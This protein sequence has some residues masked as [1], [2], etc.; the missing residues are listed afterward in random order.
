MPVA[1]APSSAFEQH[2]LAAKLHNVEKQLSGVGVVDRRTGRDFDHG[3]LAVASVTVAPRTG[4]PPL[5]PDRARSRQV[6]ERA[7]IAAGAH[8]DVATATA[9]AAVRTTL[10]NVFLA[11]ERDRSRPAGSRCDV[12]SYFVYETLQ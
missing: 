3:V 10:G 2:L 7:Q 1:L 4:T 6:D 5:R 11:P 9:V 12:Y 8:D